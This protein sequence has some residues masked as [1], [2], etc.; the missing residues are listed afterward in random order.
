MN[1]KIRRIL[2]ILGAV[3][4]LSLTAVFGYL[5]FTGEKILERMSLT[6]TDEITV[7]DGSL[8]SVN[9]GVEFRNED[10]TSCRMYIKWGDQGTDY[11]FVSVVKI[12][13]PSGKVAAYASGDRADLDMQFPLEEKG[14]YKISSEYYADA[15]ALRDAFLRLDPGSEEIRI[16]DDGSFDGFDFKGGDG[17]WSQKYDIRIIT[18][19]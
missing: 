19:K 16:E 8:E 6:Y 13:A 7:A 9:S 18:S 5:G 15:Y 14:I 3:L 17:H 4:V 2:F 1:D 10:A 11:G 12:V